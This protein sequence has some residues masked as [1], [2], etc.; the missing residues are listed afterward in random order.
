[1]ASRLLLHE[2]RRGEMQADL[3]MGEVAAVGSGALA[4][5]C[6]GLALVMFRAAMRKL[7]ESERMAQ[8][9]LAAERSDRE[10]SAFLATMSH[11]IRTPMNAILGF[12]EILR[13]ELRDERLRGF[14]DS[15]LMSGR[16]LLRLINDILD[17]SKIEAGRMEI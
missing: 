10:K 3:T 16:S 11:E 14:A 9:K 15:V 1:I 6:G 13:G 17:L 7:A 12:S 8:A 5:A 2:E 4:L